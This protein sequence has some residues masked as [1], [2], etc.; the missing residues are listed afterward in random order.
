M[1]NLE[2]GVTRQIFQKNEH[3][4]PSEGKKCL[5][6]EKKKHPFW[7]SPFFFFLLKNYLIWQ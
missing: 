7:D 5:F 1:A 3:S 6:F 2:T 4:L